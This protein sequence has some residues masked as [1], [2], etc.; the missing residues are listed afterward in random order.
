MNKEGILKE[1][2]AGAVIALGALISAVAINAF[3]VPQK[4]LSGGLTGIAML[5]SYVPNLPTRIL[6]FLINVP[7]FIF[8]FIKVS[9][10]FVMRSLFG[11]VVFSLFVQLTSGINANIQNALVGAIFGGVLSG[12]G[13]GICLRMGGSQGG[14]NV[15]SVIVHKYYSFPI[16]AFGIAVNFII[17][18]ILG[19]IVGLETAIVT[20]MSIFATNKAVDA[21]QTG[22]NRTNTVLIISDHWVEIRSKLMD[23]D[24]RGVTILHAEGGYTHQNR[25][26]LYCMA[27]SVELARIKSIVHKVDDNAFISVIDTLEIQGK[28]FETEKR[29]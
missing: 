15:I 12:I 10:R 22:F 18:T 2:R 24:H 29:F 17:L 7:M 23:E 27:H 28:G 4:L 19:I 21:V 20:L 11:L 26:I 13:S 5:L 3:L 1:C 9:G 6:V 14:L 25:P 8:A 16:G